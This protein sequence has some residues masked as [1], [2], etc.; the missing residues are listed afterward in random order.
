MK[1]NLGFSKIIV[2]GIVTIV[3]TAFYFF[4]QKYMDNSSSNKKNNPELI[5]LNNNEIIKIDN[6]KNNYSISFSNNYILDTTSRWG[7]KVTSEY[8]DIR[9]HET[10]KKVDFKLNGENFE[11]R[12]LPDQIFYQLH[13]GEK[14]GEVRSDLNGNFE[15]KSYSGKFD[16][17][18]FWKDNFDIKDIP[19]FKFS[20]Q[21]IDVNGFKAYQTTSNL[22]GGNGYIQTIVVINDNHFIEFNS[23][24]FGTDLT[25][26]EYKLYFEM[27]YS[28]K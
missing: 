28:I 1:N 21:E 9:K 4:Y 25:Q 17:K 26:S 7:G 8:G 13:Y 10:Q 23:P 16:P 6:P 19:D 24:S 27:L 5:Y 3:L 14:D 2:L 20:F 22:G 18:I 12:Y 15:I 11:L